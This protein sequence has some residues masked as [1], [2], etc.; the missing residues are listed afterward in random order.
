MRSEQRK[1]VEIDGKSVELDANWER[2]GFWMQLSTLLSG[3]AAQN[4]TLA[5][6]LAVVAIV[7]FSGPELNSYVSVSGI[8]AVLGMAAI[9][10]RDRKKSDRKESDQSCSK[11]KDKGSA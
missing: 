5:G 6:T 1:S 4:P 3:S 10:S 11:C 9:G 2:S 7:F 8:L